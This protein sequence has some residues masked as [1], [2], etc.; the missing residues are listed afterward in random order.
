MADTLAVPTT[1]PI[2]MQQRAPPTDHLNPAAMHN[3]YESTLAQI[4][5]TDTQSKRAARRPTQASSWRCRL[6]Q[7]INPHR[8]AGLAQTL[9]FNVCDLPKAPSAEDC[10]ETPRVPPWSLR[11]IADSKQRS[12]CQP[13]VRIRWLEDQQGIIRASTRRS[14]HSDAELRSCSMLPLGY[15]ELYPWRFGTFA[16]NAEVGLSPSR[17]TPALSASVYQ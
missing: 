9:S 7:S 1:E 12:L 15:V 3:T 13:R 16:G 5:G 4:S 6:R 17:I 11:E 14:S 2:K 10:D 8:S